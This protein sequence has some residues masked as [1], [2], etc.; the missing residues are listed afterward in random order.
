MNTLLPAVNG[1]G[2]ALT[3][4]VQFTPD[5]ID[6]LKRTI[7][8]GATDDELQLFVNQCKRTQLDPFARQIHAVKRYDSKTGRDVMAIQTGID[9]YR[10]IAE[11][12]GEYEGQTPVMFCGPD[13]QWTEVWL[14]PGSPAAA[15]A[16]VYKHNFK[17]PVYA[18][19]LWSEYVQ[20]YKDKQGVWQLSP[21][22]K[23]MG[24]LMLGKCAEALALRKAFPQELSG[25]YT[26]EEMSQAD[27]DPSPEEM[28]IR[29]RW[30]GWRGKL[31]PR[32]QA[33]KT[34]EELEAC[35]APFEAAVKVQNVWEQRT[36]HNEEETF[37]SLYAEHKA[38]IETDMEFQGPEGVKKW[39]A[40]VEKVGTLK[41]LASY[42]K[43]YR[44]QARLQDGFDCE[45][46]LQEKATQLGLNSYAD[47]EEEETAT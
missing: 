45:S 1:H 2:G 31:N 16:G 9:G 4:A 22:W 8:K 46:A 11:R 36:F 37:G 6:L 44:N 20:Q 39:I 17:E 41:D 27:R 38:R 13:G 34:L 25:L 40:A 30:R 24:T 42:V 33:C 7:C 21:M 18:V 3:S 29:K 32:M 19:A 26:D 15:R 12:T 47:V 10:L 14:K 35:R 5:Q 43:E 28:E 23:R